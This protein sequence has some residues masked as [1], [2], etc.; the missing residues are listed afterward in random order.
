VVIVERLTDG[1][2][3]VRVVWRDTLPSLRRILRNWVT[4]PDV[5]QVELRLVSSLGHE[6]ETLYL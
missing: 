3:S 4:G 2:G 6:F 5:L 1:V